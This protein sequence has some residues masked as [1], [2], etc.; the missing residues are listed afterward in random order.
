MLGLIFTPRIHPVESV[1]VLH[2]DLSNGYKFKQNGKNRNFLPRY[3]TVGL[4]LYSLPDKRAFVL[5]EALKSLLIN[6][7]LFKDV[8]NSWND[9]LMSS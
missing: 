6:D 8:W 2:P 4:L 7:I 1:F 3:A 9:L 5:S